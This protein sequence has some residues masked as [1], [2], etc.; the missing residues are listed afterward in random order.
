[1]TEQIYNEVIDNIFMQIENKFGSVI[2]FCKVAELDRYNLSK[3]KQRHG[4][5]SVGTFIV[6]SD[7]LENGKKTLSSPTNSV[8]NIGLFEYLSINNNAVYLNLF[9]F[10]IN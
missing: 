10:I 6:I 4:Q 3:I 5:M 7:V 2:A 8:N 9:K 1:M